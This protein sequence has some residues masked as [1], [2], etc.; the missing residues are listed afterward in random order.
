VIDLHSH[1]TM[2]DGTDTPARVVALAADAG[3]D[4]LALTDHDTLDHLA[5]A[6]AAAGER[7]IRLVAGCELSCEVGDRAPGSMHLL[8]YFVGRG[9]GPLQDR[10]V[11]LRRG[12]DARNAQILAVLRAGGID[13]SPDELAAEAG[14]GSVGRPSIARLLVRHGHVASIQEAFDTWLARGR[15]AYVERVRLDPDEAIDLV[16]QS[17]GVCSL[18]HPASLDLDGDDL[19]GLVGELAAA[20]LDGLEC[21]YAAY[22]P[23]ERASFHELADRHGLA[24]TGGSD[25]HG[26]NKPGLLVGV[27]RGDLRVPD[28]Y[29]DELESRRR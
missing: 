15:P 17:G 4:A 6:T 23:E 27:G 5:E 2:S 25:Y 11:G 20:G 8:V 28:D 7:G 24:P 9:P 26:E 13:L 1:S 16:H 21:E 22:T 14:P 29:L 19:D 18:A 3:V 10:L 12:R